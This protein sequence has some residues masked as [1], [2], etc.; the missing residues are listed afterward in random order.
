MKMAWNG[1]SPSTPLMLILGFER[2]DLPPEGVALH[3]HVHQAQ[4]RL[5]APARLSP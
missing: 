3:G 4:Q 5:I 2:I 1:L